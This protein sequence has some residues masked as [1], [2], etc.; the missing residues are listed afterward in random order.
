MSKSGSLLRLSTVGVQGCCCC[1]QRTVA[2]SRRRELMKYDF[3]DWSMSPFSTKLRGVSLVTLQRSSRALRWRLYSLVHRVLKLV[4]RLLSWTMILSS[5]T[6]GDW[7][8]KFKVLN[9]VFEY[10]WVFRWPSSVTASFRMTVVETAGANTL[11]MIINTTNKIANGCIFRRFFSPTKIVM[12]LVRMLK[13]EWAKSA[14]CRDFY[15]TQRQSSGWPRIFLLFIQ[16]V[17]C[18]QISFQFLLH[19]VVGDS[20]EWS[21]LPRALHK[22]QDL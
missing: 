10:T 1:L 20:F 12:C 13:H 2:V 9:A 4:P 22:L 14:E 8:F 3:S 17:Q 18:V 6:H 11:S 7:S 5:N 16:V 19:R 21:P 15:S